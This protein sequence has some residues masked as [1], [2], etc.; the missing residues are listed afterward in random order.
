M[1]TVFFRWG[2]PI[3]CSG[4][5]RLFSL[6]FVDYS[7]WSGQIIIFLTWTSSRQTWVKREHGRDFYLISPFRRYEVN[8]YLS[9]FALILVDTYSIFGQ[10]VL[11]SIFFGQFVDPHLVNSYSSWSVRSRFG[12]FVLTLNSINFAGKKE[13]EQ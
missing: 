10:F 8:S 4:S 1:F 9:Q 5:N 3:L 12:P 11:N 13:K 6:C 7:L 2:F